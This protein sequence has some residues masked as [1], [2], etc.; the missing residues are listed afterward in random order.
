MWDRWAISCAKTV[1]PT[2]IP[3]C[4]ADSGFSH[5]A[6]LR[7]FPSN[8]FWAECQLFC[9]WPEAYWNPKSTLPDTSVNSPSTMSQEPELPGESPYESGREVIPIVERLKELKSFWKTRSAVLSGEILSDLTK[10]Q[11]RQ[12]E[13]MGPWKFNI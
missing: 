2:F 3:H 8:R 6:P 9:S 13:L 11:L 5:P 1:R 7:C 10:D 12:R 4:S